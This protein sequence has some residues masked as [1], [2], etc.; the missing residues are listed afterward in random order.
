MKCPRCARDRP[1]DTVLWTLPDRC[2]ECQE[3]IGKDDKKQLAR[4]KELY[5]LLT[6]KGEEEFDQVCERCV[7]QMAGPIEATFLKSS[8]SEAE[9]WVKSSELSRVE[10]AFRVVYKLLTSQPPTHLVKILKQL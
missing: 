2:S 10:F 6:V 3:S 9:F 1:V 5:L 8:S 7:G 4:Y